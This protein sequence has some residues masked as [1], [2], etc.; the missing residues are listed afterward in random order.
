[1]PSLINKDIKS[2]SVSIQ[3][4]PTTHVFIISENTTKSNSIPSGI[5]KITLNRE[6][7]DSD[8]TKNIL[9]ENGLLKKE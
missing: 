6:S 3:S 2:Y 9:I 1:M 4:G 7:I 8:G 5:S